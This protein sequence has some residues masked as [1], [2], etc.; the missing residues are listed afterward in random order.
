MT[1]KTCALCKT[2]IPVDRVEVFP[3]TTLCLSC[4]VTVG[5]EFTL[6]ASDELNSDDNQPSGCVCATMVRRLILVN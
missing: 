6:V 1:E 2:T 4:S 5:G 3:E